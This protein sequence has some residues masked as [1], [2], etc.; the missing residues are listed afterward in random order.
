[1]Q[2]Q[3]LKEEFVAT[4][5]RNGETEKRIRIKILRCS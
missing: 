5:I 4:F 3:Q 1:M 2:A